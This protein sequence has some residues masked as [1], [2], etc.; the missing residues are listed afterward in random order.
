MLVPHGAD[1]MAFWVAA[2]TCS[3]MS[4][5][6]PFMKIFVCAAPK[7]PRG[8]RA[9]KTIFPASS[10]VTFSY[11]NIMESGNASMA[12]SMSNGLQNLSVSKK[13]KTVLKLGCV[14]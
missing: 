6:L 4:K 11:L 9:S 7:G 8:K 3:T 10:P 13:T 1:A 2:T 5:L 14:I 12:T